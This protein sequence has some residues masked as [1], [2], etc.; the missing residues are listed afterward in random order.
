M[1]KAP[2]IR[3]SQAEAFLLA[4]G[5]R[6]I[7][8]VFA[9][10][11]TDFAPI[12]EAV[13]AG[14]KSG[15][16]IP[17][18]ITVPH[19]TVAM[20]MA[21]GYYRATG[22]MAAVMVHVTVGTANALCGMM[23]ASRDNVPTLLCAGRTPLTETGSAGSRSLG[24]HWGQEYFDQN[25]VVRE[26][27]KWD[28]ELRTGQPVDEIVGR[29]LDIAMSEPRG[30]VYLSLPREVLAGPAVGA[31]N[32]EAVTRLGAEAPAANADAIDKAAAILAKADMP[33][34]LTSAAGRTNKAFRALSKLAEDYAIPVAQGGGLNIPYD[35]PMNLGALPGA[36]LDR[37]DA[38]LVIDSEVPWIPLVKAPRDDA[39]IIQ[40]AADPL[41]SSYPFRGFGAELLVSGTAEHT[42]PALADALKPKMRGRKRRLQTR[43]K[44]VAAE[45]KRRRQARAKVLRGAR[46][47][48]PIHPAWVAECLNA[49]INKKTVLVN[50]IAVPVDFLKLTQPRSLIGGGLAG[51]LGTGLGGALGAKLARPGAE[52][53]AAVGDGSYIFGAP[54]AAH[55]VGVAEAIPTLTLVINNSMWFAV[56]RA[57]L[58]MYPNGAAAKSNQRLPVTDLNPSPDYALTMQACGGHGETVDDPKALPDAMA[59][60]FAK[61]RGGTPALL[62]IKTSAGGRD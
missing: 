3:G 24:I 48:I 50:E 59:R 36:M 37:A 40:L 43:A 60:A 32:G 30:P 44:Q 47:Q 29:A 18:F 10:G 7:K 11:G 39:R 33:L 57:T 53:V 12:V 20:S 38:I 45:V 4:L 6:G 26:C 27:S 14:A 16:D 35:H 15:R 62:N 5:R 41:Y 61:I 51:G 9:N 1:S 2:T 49:H 22:E 46:S 31:A 23:N 25:G 19:E 8:Y 58:A 55:H 28:Y 13:V 34:I 56:H 42:I 52:V 54:T 17:Q 21:H